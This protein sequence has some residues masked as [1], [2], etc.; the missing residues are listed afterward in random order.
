MSRQDTK[1]LINYG[2]QILR[3]NQ[4]IYPLTSFIL[5]EVEASSVRICA[6]YSKLSQSLN[7]HSLNFHALL[8]F[9]KPNLRSRMNPSIM[10]TLFY[11]TI[12]KRKCIMSTDKMGENDKTSRSVDLN[13]NKRQKSRVTQIFDCTVIY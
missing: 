10:V 8:H 13:T 1:T 4:E 9:L 3:R 7:F 11:V 2:A 5:I 6:D 12:I